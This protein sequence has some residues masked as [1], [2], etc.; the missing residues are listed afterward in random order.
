MCYLIETS[1][2]GTFNWQI[3]ENMVNVMRG[4]F[5][6]DDIPGNIVVFNPEQDDI[7]NE[8]E[9][10]SERLDTLESKVTVLED[11]LE[12]IHKQLAP[13]FWH[14]VA[15]IGGLFEMGEL[16]FSVSK[17]IYASTKNSFKVLKS[18]RIANHL[19]DDLRAKKQA[20]I[21]RTIL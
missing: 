6:Q 4:F 21:R 16:V 2:I 3:T 9:T 7:V 12:Q 14:V 5:L 18:N 17:Y 20:Y 8:L 10:L 11:M 1:E 15:N 13:S 19:A